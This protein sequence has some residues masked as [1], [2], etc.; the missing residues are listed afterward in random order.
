[1]VDAHC[2]Q[3]DAAL[4]THK[5]RRMASMLADRASFGNEQC[6]VISHRPEMHE[7]GRFGSFG[8]DIYLSNE[9]VVE[10][11]CALN[12]TVLLT[13]RR[14]VLLTVHELKPLMF[15]LDNVLTDL[16]TCGRRNSRARSQ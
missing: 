15:G 8:Q 5:I 7:R 4:D 10:Q 9:P 14:R 2:V 11:C 1:M 3:I 12:H 6:I 16:H 13:N